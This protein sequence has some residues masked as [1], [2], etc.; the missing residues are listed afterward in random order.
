MP[1]F[2]KKKTP[3]DDKNDACKATVN[4]MRLTDKIFCFILLSGKN[5][6][7]FEIFALC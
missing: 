3:D 5:I 7:K 6:L 2:H 4:H 1:H